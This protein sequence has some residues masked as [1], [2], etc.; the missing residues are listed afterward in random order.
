MTD[1]RDPV[2]AVALKRDAVAGGVTHPAQ[3]IHPVVGVVCQVSY[4]VG[5]TE[6]QLPPCH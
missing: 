4:Q 6:F 3:H 1:T 2:L 5:L